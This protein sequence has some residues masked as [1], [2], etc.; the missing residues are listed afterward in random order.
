MTTLEKETVVRRVE[1]T[2]GRRLGDECLILDLHTGRY[3]S[4]GETGAVIW[5]RLEHGTTVQELANELA[6]RY[7]IDI[8]RAHSDLR[9][10]LEELLE[11]GLAE[12]VDGG[13]R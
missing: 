3:Y 11:Q 9:A 12:I 8:E 7:G 10:F 5:E 1:S 4:A 6:S 2:A 13:S